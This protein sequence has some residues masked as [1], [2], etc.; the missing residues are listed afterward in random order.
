MMYHTRRFFCMAALFTALLAVER[1]AICAQEK[2]PACG[3]E[4][5]TN[6]LVEGQLKVLDDFGQPAAVA[7]SDS[8]PMELVNLKIVWTSTS[9]FGWNYCHP[10]FHGNEPF[11]AEFP[12][13]RIFLKRQLKAKTLLRIDVPETPYTFIVANDQVSPCFVDNEKKTV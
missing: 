3:Y 13:E 2:P 7:D 5:S 11:E 8:R 9:K 10:R 1:E 6:R 4:N 12:S